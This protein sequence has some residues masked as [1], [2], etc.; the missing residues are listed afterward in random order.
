M[1]Q[2]IRTCPNIE[3]LDVKDTRYGFS[4]HSSRERIEMTEFYSSIQFNHLTKL[5]I[6][7]FHLFDGSYLLKV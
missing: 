2:M 4:V 5:S 1:G 3:E 7:E 6:C